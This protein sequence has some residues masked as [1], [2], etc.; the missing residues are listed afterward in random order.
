M[1][2]SHAIVGKLPPADSDGL[3]TVARDVADNPR[4]VTVIA[5]MSPKSIEQEMEMDST[6][7]FPRKVKFQ[8]DAVEV[9]GGSDEQFVLS[10]M[11]AAREKRTGVKALD[12]FEE[13]MRDGIGIGRSGDEIEADEIE[14]DENGEIQ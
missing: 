4:G 6:G 11:K 3:S 12:R 1:S 10:T 13:A 8:I 9:I 7:E 5:R 14:A 2:V